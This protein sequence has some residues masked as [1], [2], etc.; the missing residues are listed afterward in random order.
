MLMSCVCAITQQYN[1]IGARIVFVKTLSAVYF[2]PL[3]Y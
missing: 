3:H 2:L 1:K